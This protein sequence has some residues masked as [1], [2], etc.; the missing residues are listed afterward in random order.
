MSMRIL[1]AEDQALQRRILEVGLRQAGYE[2]DSTNDG[3]AAWERFLEAPS[4]MVIT[5]WMMPRLD[6]VDLIRRIRELDL[7]RHTY[8]ILLTARDKKDDV[9]DGLSSG[10]DDYLTKP[11]DQR[12]LE[13]RV[14]IGQRMI[15]LEDR[16]LASQERLERLATYDGL[17]GLL[18]R[19]A[20]LERAEGEVH[21]A[22]RNGTP[23]GVVMVD[24]DRFKSVNDEH[25]HVQG[26]EVLRQVAN[27]LSE[28]VRPYDLVG[29]W[30]GEEFLLV[31]PGTTLEEARQVAERVREGVAQA[32]IETPSGTT[33]QIHISAG[34]ASSLPHAR[35]KMDT[36][37]L[38]A[39]QALLVAKRSGRNQV[40]VA[41]IPSDEQASA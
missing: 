21:R 33:L 4:R 20:L 15:S 16:L 5:D 2:T 30:G 27:A 34:V 6:G 1:I 39:D 28:N 9:V 7:D 26:D 29:R 32:A 35:V 17:T 40:Q 8:V 14:A 3:Q 23:T 11:F 12:E 22:V 10:A 37:L 41:G 19:Q 25:G 31:L 36:L 18:N 13:A 24:V 38:E